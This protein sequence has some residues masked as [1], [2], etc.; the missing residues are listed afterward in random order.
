[1]YRRLEGMLEVVYIV[2]IYSLF[3][4]LAERVFWKPYGVS[5]LSTSLDEVLKVL[6]ST[7]IKRVFGGYLRGPMKRP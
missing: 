7:H 5:I 1:M 4:V 3:K 6:W 2:L